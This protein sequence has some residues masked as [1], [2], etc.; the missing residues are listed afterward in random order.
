MTEKELDAVWQRIVSKIGESLAAGACQKWINPLQP[1]AM[2]DDILIL[3]APNELVQ[4]WVKTR[5]MNILTD[6]VLDTTN[7]RLAINIDVR[8]KDTAETEDPNEIDLSKLNFSLGKETE[9]EK[10]AKGGEERKGRELPK[11][12]APGDHS[13]IKSHYT[14]DNFVTGKSNQYA[15]AVAMAVAAAPGERDE[16]NPLFM[17]GGVGLGK[18]H[19]MHAIGNQILAN[20]PNMRVLYVSSE[21]FTNELINSIKDN[22]PETFRLKYRNIDVLMVD[23]IQFISGKQSTQEEFFHTFNTLR[24]AKKQIILSSDRPPK[25]VSDIEERLRSRFAGGNIADIQAPDLETRI[26]I[27]RK[28]AQTEKM[29]VPNDAIV[30]IASRIDSNIRELEGALTRVVAYASLTG[31]VINTD[32]VNEALKN[33]FDNN[34]PKAIT[35]EIIEGV[36]ADYYK[37]TVE[38]L[39]AKKRSRDIAHPRQVAMYLCREMTDTSLPQIGAF[40]GGRDHTTVIHA[41]EKIGHDRENNVSVAREIKEIEERLNAM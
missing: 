38:N 21:T 13:T 17:Y 36:I 35:M 22:H 16:N 32:L 25:D 23:D 14:F 31:R 5:Y 6:A 24:D 12:I 40:F 7:K 11:P 28:K 30:F 1:V 9:A 10:D 19:L 26:A 27:L 33:I 37:V 8:K 41:C 39:K 18:T 29:S 4:E 20:N 34:A 2:D 3:T 15:N